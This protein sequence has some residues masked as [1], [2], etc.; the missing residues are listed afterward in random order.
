VCA[1]GLDL[2][3]RD[4][5]FGVAA[6][7]DVVEHFDDD[8]TLMAEIRRVVNHGGHLLLSVPAYQWAWSRH[9]ELAG[10]ERRYTRRSVSELLTRS[11]FEVVRASY[12][13]A[14]TFPFFVV[15]RLRSR[16]GGRGPERVGES[17]LPTW[18]GRLLGSLSR[19][20]GWWLS[21][22][23]LPFGSSVFVLARRVG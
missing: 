11:G 19:L 10:H 23:D 21:H 15:D 12:G 7:F 18:V 6:A 5:S 2:P 17:Q 9:D 3:F 1:D 14:A 4:G 16:I 13:F 22:G 20:D 8:D